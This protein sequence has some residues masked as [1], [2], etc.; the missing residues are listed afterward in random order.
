LSTPIDSSAVECREACTTPPVGV[1]RTQEGEPA[2]AAL[3]EPGELEVLLLSID[4]S[5]AV[6]TA[7]QFYTWAQGLLQGVVPHRVLFCLRP[8]S[9]PTAYVLDTFSALVC[10][11]TEFGALL[12][13]DP[14]LTP[15]LIE[16]WKGA[17]H[18]PVAR[19]VDQLGQLG[20]SALARAFQRVGASRVAM[21]GTHD[22]AGEMTTLFIFASALSDVAVNQSYLL[23]LIVPFLSAAW[24][25]SQVSE[26]APSATRDSCAPVLTAREREVLRW[27]YLGKGNAEV[28]AILRISALT[29]KNHVQKILRKLNVANRAQAVGKALDARLIAP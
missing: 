25:R 20:G 17:R 10:D 7:R 28:G 26:R 1:D 23:R 15:N 4:A 6:S 9:E 13:R 5:L 19:A 11:A 21:H 18:T 24:I 29:V 16:A 27:I 14:V 12:I 8:G 22:A 3:R 2:L